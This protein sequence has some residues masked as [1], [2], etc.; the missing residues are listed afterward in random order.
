MGSLIR[1]ELL[2]HCPI[3]PCQAN[4]YPMNAHNLNWYTQPNLVIFYI[5]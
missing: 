2:I 4:N 5:H 3:G 1:F